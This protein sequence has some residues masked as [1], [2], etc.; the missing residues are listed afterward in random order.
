M[1][2]IPFIVYIIIC[3]IIVAINNLKLRKIPKENVDEIRKTKIVF[4][5]ILVVLCVCF[6]AWVYITANASYVALNN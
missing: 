1:P 5:T 6:S 4:T 3:C 2:I